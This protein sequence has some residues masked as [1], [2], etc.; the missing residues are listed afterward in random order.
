MADLQLLSVSSGGAKQPPR[1]ATARR[2]HRGLSCSARGSWSPRRKLSASFP[3]RGSPVLRFVSR[4]AF[5]DHLDGVEGCLL[6]AFEQALA[7]AA[8]RATAV[9]DA[10]EGWLDRVRA[11]LTALLEFFDEQPALARYCVVHSAQA[12]PAVLAARSEVLDRLARVLDDEHARARGYPPRPFDAASALQGST[13]LDWLQKP[14]GRPNHRAASVLKVIGAEPGLN[15]VE[16][17]LRASLNKTRPRP[18]GSCCVWRGS[19]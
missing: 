18:Q 16:V 7:L 13:A 2:I 12:G 19:G 11:A 17:A 5:D 15:N 14:G 4:E 8:E 3:L 9:F 6:A 1:V 10:Q